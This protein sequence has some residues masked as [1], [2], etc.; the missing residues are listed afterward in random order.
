[1][2]SPAHPIGRLLAK[3]YCLHVKQSSLLC[4]SIQIPV[5]SD[6]EWYFLSFHISKRPAKQIWSPKILLSAD[7]LIPEFN[8]IP[9]IWSITQHV[10]IRSLNLRDLS[11]ETVVFQLQS[12]LWIAFNQPTPLL[13]TSISSLTSARSLASL[14]LEWLIRRDV[15]VCNLPAVPLD[16]YNTY[17]TPLC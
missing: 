9:M 2:N 5:V 6:R 4:S 8:V 1:M 3:P 12:K 10:V 15:T 13:N 17:I 16:I 14:S 11:N 7:D